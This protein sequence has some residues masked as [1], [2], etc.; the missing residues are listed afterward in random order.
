MKWGHRPLCLHRFNLWLG[1]SSCPPTSHKR[2][3]FLSRSHVHPYKRSHTHTHTHTHSLHSSGSHTR[4][5]ITAG[6]DASSALC[7]LLFL[8][9]WT[10]KKTVVEKSRGREKER[11]GVFTPRCQRDH[12]RPAY[13]LSGIQSYNSSR[14]SAG[15][16]L[17][18]HRASWRLALCHCSKWRC[19]DTVITLNQMMIL[20]SLPCDH[21]LV[22]C[23]N[24]CS[25]VYM[26]AGFFL[27]N[28]IDWS[29]QAFINCFFWLGYG[30]GLC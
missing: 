13:C 28:Y 11:W 23:Q 18:R 3:T 10:W 21:L 27:I 1:I 4:C 15:F 14:W 8:S 16:G 29:K 22:F 26:A 5:I 30:T 20:S 2:S 25:L 7:S 19:D 6:A 17:N 9:V 12:I 24:I